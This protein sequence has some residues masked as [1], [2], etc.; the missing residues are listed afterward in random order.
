M[1]FLTELGLVR[2]TRLPQGWTNSPSIFQ[3]IMGKVHYRQIYY[4]VQPFLDD[5]GIKGF[6]DRYD[7]VKIA[8]SIRKFIFEHAQI[9]RQ[10]MYNI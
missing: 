8:S 3:C 9:F 1:A 6:K 4:E 7:D 2:S 10:F 5:C